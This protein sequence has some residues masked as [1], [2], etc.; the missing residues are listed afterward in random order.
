VFNIR[1]NMGHT[2]YTLS[3]LPR[4]QRARYRQPGPVNLNTAVEALVPAE[5]STREQLTSVAALT[6]SRA[7]PR[8]LPFLGLMLFGLVALPGSPHPSWCTAWT[9]TLSLVN[10]RALLPVNTSGAVYPG[11]GPARLSW[12]PKLQ[13]PR[14]YVRRLYEGRLLSQLYRIGT[15][16]FGP[17]Y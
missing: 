10:S 5:V 9:R 13:R 7:T 8:Q 11:Q 6:V 12:F 2:I 15:T 16:P 4:Q 17:V 1:R 3:P 14:V